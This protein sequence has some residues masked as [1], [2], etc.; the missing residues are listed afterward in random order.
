MKSKLYLLFVL[1]WICFPSHSFANPT[2]TT[3]NAL[4][5]SNLLNPNVSAIGWIQSE[6]GH[7]QPSEEEAKAFQL[8]E[9]ELGL[10]SVID[11]YARADLFIAFE[12]E[13]V[14]IEE[15]YLTW[16]HLPGDL[17]AKLGKF[18]TSFGK[19]NR[20]HAP[21]TAFAVRPFAHEAYFG[22]EGFGGTGGSLSWHVPNPLFLIN[23]EVD[24]IN[25]PEGEEVPGFD[26]AE[27]GDLTYVS[28]LGGFVDVT[29]ASHFSLGFNYAN[30]AVGQEFKPIENSTETLRTEFYGLDVTFR[31]KNPRR[32][33]YRSFFW[34]LEVFWNEREL[35][36]TV[37]ENSLGF[38]SHLEYQFARRWRVG[39][40]YDYSESPTDKT[41]QEQGGLLYLTFWPSEFSSISLQGLHKNLDDNTEENLGFLKVT[42][43]IG[44]HGSHAF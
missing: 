27:K 42:F 23:W 24:V 1:V 16:T 5:S 15:G 25:T 18:R 26:E 43:N 22:E 17:A 20:I 10:Q 33:I 14:E 36:T 13:S 34:T 7:R 44:P 35:S 8:K 21:E 12:G 32:A 3:S 19:F 30:G 4:Q 6:V 9:L 38:F 29:E 11:P 37:Q 40:R 41:V 31:W 2:S 39:G 28:R